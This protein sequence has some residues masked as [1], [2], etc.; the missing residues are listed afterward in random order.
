MKRT[1]IAEDK[2]IEGEQ[3][4]KQA[5]LGGHIDASFFTRLRPELG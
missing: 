3:N 4:R 1:G 5:R 2:E